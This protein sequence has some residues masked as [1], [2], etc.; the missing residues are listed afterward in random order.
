V[1]DSHQMVVRSV[2]S[3]LDVAHRKLPHQQ[4]FELTLLTWCY[5]LLVENLGVGATCVV[6]AE[7][8][9]QLAVELLLDIGD[10]VLELAALGL[11]RQQD[12]GG[13]CWVSEEEG[14][15]GWQ[16]QKERGWI[17]V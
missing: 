17:T 16:V 15:V 3:C 2:S 6:A 1:S 11:G 5:Y 9:G 13:G 10:V 14:L 7:G 4:R 12:E 8:V